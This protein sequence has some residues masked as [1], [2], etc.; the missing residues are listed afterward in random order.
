MTFVD[1]FRLSFYKFADLA[2][3]RQYSLKT[4]MNWEIINYKNLTEDNY[5]YVLKEEKTKKI[6][7][8]FPGTLTRFQLLEEALGS[9]FVYFKKTK[10]ILLSKY[11]G[12]RAKN[13]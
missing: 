13:F 8:T 11:F 9:N 3:K 7:V 5:F 12:E 2:Y 10:N 1:K 4:Y 6:I